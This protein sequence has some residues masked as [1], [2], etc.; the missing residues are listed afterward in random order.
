[1][2][3]VLTYSNNFRRYEFDYAEKLNLVTNL[4][5]GHLKPPPEPEFHFLYCVIVENLWYI[6]N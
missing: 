4:S 2:G 3:K 1:M 6:I 5:L